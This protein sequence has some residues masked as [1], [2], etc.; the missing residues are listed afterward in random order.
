MGWLTNKM[1]LQVFGCRWTAGARAARLAV[2][3]GIAP[4]SLLAAQA[5]ADSAPIYVARGKVSNALPSPR[6]IDAGIPLWLSIPLAD[7]LRSYMTEALRIYR[8]LGDLKRDWNADDLQGLPDDGNRYEVIDGELFVGPAPTWTH[9]EAVALLSRRL[10]DSLDRQRVG[11]AFI[12]PADVIFSPRRAV[13]TDV[14]VV[15]LVDGRRPE[16]FHEVQRLLVAVEVLYPGT[17][18]ADRVAKRLMFR[19]EGVGEY[20]IVDLDA[21]TFERSTPIHARPEILAERLEWLPD[22]A[23]EPFEIDLVAYF[24][25]VLGD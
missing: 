25:Q 8:E 24:A 14:F 7:S 2:V 20:W 5:T 4:L 17:A 15:P 11:H 6:Q 19:D 9:Q 13:Q 23:S 3:L 16:A 12:A 1:A 22:G 10:A 21:R 18:R